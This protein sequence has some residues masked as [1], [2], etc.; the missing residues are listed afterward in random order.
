MVWSWRKLVH[1]LELMRIELMFAS[2][3]HAWMVVLLSVSVEPVARLNR[4][5]VPGLG[6]GVGWGLV[7]GGLVGAGLTLFGVGLNDVMDV[8][9]DRAFSPSRPI[10]AGRVA[11]PAAMVAGLA[12]LLLAVAA[13][14]PLGRASV[15][16]TVAVAGAILFYN[17]AGRHLPAIGTLTLGAM[18]AVAAMI[19]N[20]GLAYLW[21]VWVIFSVMVASAMVVHRLEF[22][23]PRLM[24]GDYAGAVGG[25]AFVSL[26]MVVWMTQRGGLGASDGL[27]LWAWPLAGVAVLVAGGWWL[28]RQAGA[29]EQPRRLRRMAAGRVERWTALGLIVIDAGWLL[30]TGHWLGGLLLLKLAVVAYVLRRVLEVLSDLAEPPPGYRLGSGA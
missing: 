18:H 22:K 10:P 21:P 15:L 9:R 5:L 27:R 19:V 13:S 2:V 1:L 14:V 30:G 29:G 25:W 16:L 11:L 3:S 7:L 12:A 26:V 8:R 28:V 6:W 23:R 4:A 17:A 24:A 20:P